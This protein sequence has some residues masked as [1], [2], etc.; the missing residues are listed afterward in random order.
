MQTGQEINEVENSGFCTQ[1]PT[2]FACNIGKNKYIVQVTTMGIRLLMG[3]KQLQHIPLDLGSPIVHATSADP[4]LTLL[5][6][7]SQVI[8][9]TLRE[10]RG[11]T[12]LVV[13]KT[14]ISRVCVIY[15]IIACNMSHENILNLV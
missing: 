4:Y 1:S 5:T 9:F 2:I 10:T 15:I 13:G 8:N 3:A 6:E 14:A 12:K 11:S 7:D